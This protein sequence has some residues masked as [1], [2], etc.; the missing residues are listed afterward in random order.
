[1][2]I[3]EY[4]FD[5]DLLVW[6][7]VLLNECDVFVDGWVCLFVWLLLCGSWEV[8]VLM[9]NVV[10]LLVCLCWCGWL[11]VGVVLVVGL[12]LYVVVLWCYV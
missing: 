7:C 6:L 11:L 4:D 9:D 8:F 12:V 5:Y 3:Y 1:M 2:S 10:V